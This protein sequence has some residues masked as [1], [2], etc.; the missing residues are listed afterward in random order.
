MSK[1]EELIDED[2]CMTLG[3]LCDYLH[4]DIGVVVSKT[5]VHRALQGMLYLTKQLCIEKDTMNS[6]TNKEKRKTF[7][8]EL[9]KHIKKGNM[10][11]F[12]D[13]TNFNL[14]LIRNEGWSRIGERAVVHFP[15]PKARTFISRVAFP[16]V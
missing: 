1:L 13:E 3:Q 16:V 2:S 15:L 6:N 11:V 12:Q 8:D 9:N 14:Y 4:S 7:V 5:S 10:V